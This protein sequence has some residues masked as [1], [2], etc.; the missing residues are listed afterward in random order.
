MK[1]GMNDRLNTSSTQGRVDRERVDFAN[2]VG[3][4]RREGTN[5][6]S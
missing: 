6:R 4:V 1:L 5:V 3:G 2:E